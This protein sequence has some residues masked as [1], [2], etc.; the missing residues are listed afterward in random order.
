MKENNIK[1]GLF[2]FAGLILLMAAFFY[3]GKG[4]NLFTSKFEI[5]A[6]FE[7]AGGLKEGSNV[8]FA[9]IQAGTVS[10]IVLIDA[11]TIEVTMFIDKKI[12][13]HIDRN[14]TVAIGTEGVIGNTIINITPAE[15]I[16]GPITDGGYLAVYK[17][18]GVEEMLNTLSKTNNNIEDISKSLKNTVLR[19]NSSETL[20]LIEDE[21]FSDNIKQS[22]QNVH[23]STVNV[24]QVTA[25]LNDMLIAVKQGKGA[26][27]L[28]IAD[29]DFEEQVRQTFGNINAVSKNLEG[30]SMELNDFSQALNNGKGPLNALVK[31][32]TLT[33]KISISLENIK[34]GTD[35]FNQN[36]EALKHNFLF[37]GYF[38]KKAR[39]KEKKGD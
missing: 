5:K 17:K 23:Q 12:A 8:L 11:N 37:R 35:G 15:K 38:K 18:V 2:V 26:A 33:E 31:D 19:I 24:A 4:N 32:S 22:M 34:Q 16:L 7:N 39:E 9:G 14:A 27:G 20:K 1:L 6:K 13:S 10:S 25:N 3:I 29:K 36:M 21:K 30:I 28:L